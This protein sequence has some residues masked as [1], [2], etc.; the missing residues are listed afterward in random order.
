MKGH[1][2]YPASCAL[3]ISCICF[4]SNPAQAQTQTGNETVNQLDKQGKKQGLWIEQGGIKEIY[5]RD[6]LKEGVFKS[7]FRKDGKLE[8]LGSY[9]H[10]MLAGDWYYFDELGCLL[11]IEQAITLNATVKVDRGDGTLVTPSY[12]SY[13][14]GYYKNGMLKEEGRALYSESIELGDYVKQGP[15][16]YYDEGGKLVKEEN[17][18]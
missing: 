17:H 9:K 7:Y 15:W 2:L 6:G 1:P 11:M 18:K 12:S 13:Y 8:A 16:K 4:I 14:K 10:G 3:M 5:Y